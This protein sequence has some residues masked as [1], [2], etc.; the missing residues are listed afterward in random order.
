[1]QLIHK[2][3][4]EAESAISITNLCR[5]HR[6]SIL[7]HCINKIQSTVALMFS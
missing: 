2:Y 1:M 4:C 5:E 7:S 3:F 6:M